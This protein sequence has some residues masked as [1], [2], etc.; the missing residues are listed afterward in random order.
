MV[1][2]GY[3][4]SFSE[5]KRYDEARNAFLTAI[6]L[7]AKD[8]TW[9]YLGWNYARQGYHKEAVRCYAEAIKIN[10]D[11]EQAFHA[12]KASKKVLAK[13]NG[14]STSSN[15]YKKYRV[16]ADSLTLRLKP[17]KKGKKIGS[18]PNNKRV[19]LIQ[20]EGEKQTIS[21]AL[22]FLSF[23]FSQASLR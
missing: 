3:G 14:K 1:W 21:G 5:L 9:R 16:I 19:K 13:K 10:P 12:L 17:T 8:K 4:W 22:C 20:Y 7:G 18:I 15:N 11:N 6:S 23:A 2:H